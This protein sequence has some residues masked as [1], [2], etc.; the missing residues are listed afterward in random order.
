VRWYY[1]KYHGV[2]HS[3]HPRPGLG[4]S[5]VGPNPRALLLFWSRNQFG[6]RLI[7]HFKQVTNVARII[8]R[9][10]SGPCHSVGHDSAARVSSAA[11]AD[12]YHKNL[13]RCSYTSLQIQ[14]GIS[15]FRGHWYQEQSG[16]W[17]WHISWVLE[18]FRAGI[19]GTNLLPSTVGPMISWYNIIYDISTAH[20]IIDDI[21]EWDHDIY[22]QWCHLMLND[23][24]DIYHNIYMHTFA[25]MVVDP[26]RLRSIASNHWMIMMNPDPHGDADLCSSCMVV[27]ALQGSGWAPG[28]VRLLYPGASSMSCPDISRWLWCC[29]PSAG[30][31]TGQN[32][33]MRRQSDLGLAGIPVTYSWYRSWHT[34][35]YRVLVYDVI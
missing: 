24:G 21:M 2:H 13:M 20:D 26:G 29:W 17:F 33:N 12:W 1:D 5:L 31:W 10:H 9:L 32:Q 8:H 27:V 19:R 4:W 35:W 25:R 28:S 3:I 18:L 16:Y 23:I 7:V 30:S 34:L 22:Q 11:S 14:I 15:E 6:K